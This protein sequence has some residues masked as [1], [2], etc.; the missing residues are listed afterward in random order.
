MEARTKQS[1]QPHL[2]HTLWAALYHHPH[3]LAR[4]IPDNGGSACTITMTLK[5]KSAELRAGAVRIGLLGTLAVYDE[6]GRPAR[7]GGHRVRML[8]I[9]L[10]LDAG[11]V[12]PAYLLIER[13]WDGDPPANAGN[14]L[15]S[16]VSRLRSS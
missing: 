3:E 8:L 6:V 13:L 2:D 14:S 16:L 10:A 4:V 9:L 12:V 1:W 5:D 7:I 15:Q 11:R